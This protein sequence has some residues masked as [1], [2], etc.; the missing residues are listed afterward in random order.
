MVIRFFM[1]QINYLKHEYYKPIDEKY[2]GMENMY[3]MKV[4]VVILVLYMNILKK[5]NLIQII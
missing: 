5:L 1:D 2:D 4:T 3:F